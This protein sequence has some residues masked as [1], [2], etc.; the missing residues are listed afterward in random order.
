MIRGGCGCRRGGSLRRR[1]TAVRIGSVDTSM[2][3]I[4][5]R[6][7]AGQSWTEHWDKSKLTY[8][9]LA[10]D[11][12]QPKVDR[13]VT[14]EWIPFDANSYSWDK[15]QLTREEAEQI[16]ITWPKDEPVPFDPHA[17]DS[18]QFAFEHGGEAIGV[19]FAPSDYPRLYRVIVDTVRCR[20]RHVEFDYSR[21]KH[22]FEVPLD[23]PLVK[24]LRGDATAD[25]AIWKISAKLSQAI[26]SPTVEG[27]VSLL[28][29]HGVFSVPYTYWFDL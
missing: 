3:T 23:G 20:L 8:M 13:A 15:S 10:S 18:I 19:G 25:K 11:L 6:N 22:V 28:C 24:A 26:Q 9:I 21:A 29:W 14:E 7:V 1:V 17:C 2:I 27:I 5:V 16:A 12:P 4:Q